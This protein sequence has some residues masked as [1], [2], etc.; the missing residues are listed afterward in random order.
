MLTQNYNIKNTKAIILF[1]S[2]SCNLKCQYCDMASHINKKLHANEAKKVKESLVNGQYL[3]TLKTSFERLE[4]N[5]NQIKH[6]ELWGQEPTLT[7]KEFNIMFPEF[8]KL[9]PNLSSSMFSTNGVGFI[10]NIVEY[11]LTVQK[12]VNNNFTIKIQ[13]SYD[14]DIASKNNRGVEPEII[15]NNIT[16]F[17]NK[18][19]N[20]DL[21]HI[22]IEIQFHN[23]I[24]ANLINYYSDRSRA[25]EL[26]EFQKNFSDLS[27]KYIELNTNPNVQVAPFSPGLI[28]PYNATTQE[29][30]NL[31]EFFKNCREIGKELPYKNWPGLAHQFYH[32][33]LDIEYKDI[34][35]FLKNAINYNNINIETLKMLSSAIS[36][37]YNYGVLKVRYD[38]T[39]I[40]C[41]NAIMGLTEKELEDKTDGDSL[42]QKRRLQKHFYPNI[43]FDSDEIIDNYLYQTNLSHEQSYLEAF[44]QIAHLLLILLKANQI[45]KKYQNNQL[46]LKAAYYISIITNCPYNALMMS[47]SLYGHYAGYIR[48]FCN[49]FLDLIEEEAE[50]Y[51]EHIGDNNNDI[52]Q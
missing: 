20:I 16:E 35:L 23:V 50:Y 30:K 14:G 9:C 43:I 12:T 25:N 19:N 49:G 48:F 34:Y 6:F 36:C 37:G 45:D 24:D 42:I 7:L 28:T 26:Y 44:S 17:F 40:L 18:I 13:F 4:I 11:I 41:Q 39:M 5:P 3:Q 22:K 27:K 47:G 8:Y 51:K 38:G 2:E 33:F 29:G 52:K 10:D 21:K 31:A 15:L 32:R 46:F 1:T